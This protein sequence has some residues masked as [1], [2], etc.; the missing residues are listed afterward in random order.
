MQSL[1]LQSQNTECQSLNGCVSVILVLPS[2]LSSAPGI[3]IWHMDIKYDNF[4]GGGGQN[5]SSLPPNYTEVSNTS[6]ILAMANALRRHKRKWGL[7]GGIH[8]S[9]HRISDGFACICVLLPRIKVRRT[10]GFDLPA[11]MP[12]ESAQARVGGDYGSGQVFR[13][14]HDAPELNQCPRRC[15]AADWLPVITAWAT[16]HR[17]GR[18]GC[19]F[20]RI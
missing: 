6:L 16:N 4:G 8:L 10:N 5:A 9:G 17:S 3:R 2:R 14:L 7:S 18:T 13:H 11:A 1:F 19:H 15:H 12:V 20:G